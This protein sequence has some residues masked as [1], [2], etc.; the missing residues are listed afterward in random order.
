MVTTQC[1]DDSL[2]SRPLTTL[3]TDFDGVIWFIVQADSEVARE[4]EG[5][6]QSERGLRERRRRQVRG[7]DRQ[8]AD[9]EGQHE[10]RRTVEPR[11]QSLVRGSR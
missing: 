6:A 9:H 4:I 3:D 10:S 8:R 2:R 7:G 5:L 1:E 11:V